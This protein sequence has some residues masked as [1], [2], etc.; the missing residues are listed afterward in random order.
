MAS[1]F[2]FRTLPI[3]ALAVVGTIAATPVAAE[4]GP[5][6]TLIVQPILSPERTR[7]AFQPLCDY[8]SKAVQQ[9]CTLVTSPNFLAYWQ[10]LRKGSDYNLAFD[11]A[12][13]TDY[14]VQKF[15]WQVLAKIPDTVSYSLIVSDQNPIFDAGELMAKPVATLGTPSI[16]AARLNALFPNPS[17]KPLLVE[18]DTAEDGMKLLL[19]GK[20]QAAIL[21]TPLVSQQMQSGGGISVV[22]TTEAIP[23]IA[24][25]ASPK[26]D[27]NLRNNLRTA[28]V[29]ASSSLD[30]RKMLEA[31][32]FE[33]FE[34][35]TNAV[36][37][38]QAKLLQDYWGY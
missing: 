10:T 22:L 1:W 17:R 11:A 12:H 8:L 23:H 7:A 25:S 14:R 27:A 9:P 21:P 5:G 15:G 2:S 35:A 19:A 20:V 13:F 3:L 26:L 16:G 29:N 34:A 18:V 32:G 33:R 28:L 36:Y 30:G 6:L 37:A 24:V 38:G 31:I 4:T